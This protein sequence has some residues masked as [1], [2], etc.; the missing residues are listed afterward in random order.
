M[1]KSKE[2]LLTEY[3]MLRGKYF[4]LF[5]EDMKKF[6]KHCQAHPLYSRVVKHFDK[7][8]KEINQISEQEIELYLKEENS[9]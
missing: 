4:N 3:K 9:K 5:E 6:E 1:K 2:Q 7:S 8:F